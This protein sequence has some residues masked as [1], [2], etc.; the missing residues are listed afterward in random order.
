MTTEDKRKYFNTNRRKGDT[1]K[2]VKTLSGR[3]SR[4]TIFDALKNGQKYKP[5]KHQVVIDTAYEIV[6]L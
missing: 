4:K 3:V 6:N 2:L 1:E 5:S